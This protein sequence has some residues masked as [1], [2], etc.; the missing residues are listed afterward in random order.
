MSWHAW[1]LRCLSALIVSTLASAS[2]AGDIVSATVA[3]NNPLGL[4]T[5]TQEM[6]IEFASPAAAA[7][8]SLGA[9]PVFD[10]KQ[11]AFT[12]RWDD[13][14]PALLKM[15]QVMAERGLRGTF[16]INA[17]NFERQKKM[18]DADFAR[19]L[20]AD[21]CSI[22]GH[23]MTH[24][25]LPT[26]CPNEIF[27]EML[28]NRIEREAQTDRPINSF[29]FP[30]GASSSKFD[31]LALDATT[32]SVLRAGYHNEV[33]GYGNFHDPARNP[34]V[35]SGEITTGHPTRPGDKVV[36]AARM[37]KEID[38]VIGNLAVST[39]RS[40][41]MFVGVHAS[42]QGDE[43]TK[44]GDL[45]ARY[46]GNP[47]WWYCNM[48]QYA[49]YARQAMF[50]QLE[51]LSIDGST[52]KYRI[53]RPQT[54]DL[55]DDVP[56]TIEVT[57][58]GVAKV[59]AD[60]FVVD[61]KEA[62][63]RTLLNVHHGDAY[64]LVSRI[65]T[66]NNVSNATANDAASASTKFAGVK[67]WI[68]YDASADA[69]QLELT[70]GGATPLT[71]VE[72]TFR[73][74]PMAKNGVRIRPLGTSVAGR[75]HAESIKLGERRAEAVYGDG[76]AYFVAEIDFTS[77][78]RRNRLFATTRL[79]AN[80]VGRPCVRDAAMMLGPIGGL[81]VDADALRHTSD[82]SAGWNDLSK[83]AT[84]QWFTASARQRLR[85]TDKGVSFYRDDNANWRR[86]AM[87]QGD[88][89]QTYVVGLDFTLSE[90]AD[91]K[92]ISELKV[93]SVFLNG[94]QVNGVDV[95]PGARAER[96]RLV[97][98]YPTDKGNGAWTATPRYLAIEPS[99]GTLEYVVPTIK[100]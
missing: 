53:T 2:R 36:D 90:P 97:I 34:F 7:S 71:D 98:V 16:Y 4:R 18:Y 66:V 48:T 72:V 81:E 46:T 35:R 57:G 63:G 68:V 59:I 8:A 58:G 100:P 92:L 42:Y 65:D 79:P 10:G 23:S 9:T 84:Q 20:A 31:P 45:I 5:Y 27:Y 49:A 64:P 13:N 74:P 55:G 39:K 75:S 14:N 37:Q 73:L 22:G 99:A 89:P 96:N 91:L 51:R 50:T 83:D 94:Q 61:K 32:T 41:C 17:S 80:T 12:A 1:V 87:K 43:W 11:W 86:A 56:L 15:H 19:Q 60:G 54:V 26:L 95:I 76:L 88:T 78:G 52:A 6:T 24:D 62:A 30:F 33:F 67:A 38:K 29:V 77:E 82:R 70:N 3:A 85:L 40:Y 69:L 21:G 44:V 93:G 25:P 28:A 47:D